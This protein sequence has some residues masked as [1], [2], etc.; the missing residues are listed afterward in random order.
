MTFPLRALLAGALLAATLGPATAPVA[1][2]P[3]LTWSCAYYKWHQNDQRWHR[4]WAAQSEDWEKQP[5][6]ARYESWDCKYCVIPYGLPPRN[7]EVPPVHVDAELP[8]GTEV[9]I[10]P[11]GSPIGD[12]V[13]PA[14]E[15]GA[16]AVG[17]A[18]DCPLV[19]PE[20]DEVDDM[21]ADVGGGG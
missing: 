13:E 3:D 11:Q 7:D 2:A 16:Q 1:A 10:A 5:G 6:N 4:V 19:P 9:S 12:V 18:P 15:A 20:Y 8:G 21:R 17:L 14:G